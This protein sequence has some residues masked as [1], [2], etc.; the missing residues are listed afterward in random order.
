VDALAKKQ[1]EKAERLAAGVSAAELIELR[2]WVL[3]QE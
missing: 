3:G 1:Q 2:Q